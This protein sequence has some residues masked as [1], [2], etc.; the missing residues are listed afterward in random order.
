MA[1][2]SQGSP[3]NWDPLKGTDIG[4]VGNCGC[5]KGDQVGLLSIAG[6]G[7][8]GGVGTSV[9][10]MANQQSPHHKI[11]I[12]YFQPFG[13]RQENTSRSVAER[14]KE[15][16]EKRLKEPGLTPSAAAN[17]E[18]A[19]VEIAVAKGAATDALKKEIANATASGQVIEL[20]I[21]LG[22][23]QLHNMARVETQ[24]GNLTLQ[25]ETDI[26]KTFVQT[27]K[28]SAFWQNPGHP[29]TGPCA[30]MAG[31]L[32]S[33]PGHAGVFLHVPAE[34]SALPIGQAEIQAGATTIANAAF[35]AIAPYIGGERV[36]H[37]GNSFMFFGFDST[38]TPWKE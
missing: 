22:E 21:G 25:S 8:C 33:D 10:I 28:E 9:P 16:L 23:D 29:G 37:K 17:V 6:S 34:N 38:T 12:S 1:N 3:A 11:I 30:E 36:E 27:V 4:G 14:A 24:V 19:L 18:I 32:I 20:W 13:G 35:N 2:F 7:W 26:L 31:D 5:A 15:I